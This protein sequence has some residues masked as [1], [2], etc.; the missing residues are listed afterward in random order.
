MRKLKEYHETAWD[1]ILS[2]CMAHITLEM[3]LTFIFS[4]FGGGSGTE[5]I[6]LLNQIFA[7]FYFILLDLLG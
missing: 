6:F 5:K 1:L 2:R 7:I 3:F 4:F